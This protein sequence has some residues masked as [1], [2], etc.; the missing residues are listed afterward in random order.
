[1]PSVSGRQHRAMEAAAHGTSNLGI[2]K[3]VGQ[4]FS[5]ADKGRK[6]PT[7]H[8]VA[9]MRKHKAPMSDAES[10]RAEDDAEK[11]G[12]YGRNSGGVGSG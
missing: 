11:K 4:E 8:M 2:P 3:K 5:Q 10:D 7:K 1:M 9:A 12:G 6:F